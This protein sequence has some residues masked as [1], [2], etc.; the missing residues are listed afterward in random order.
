VTIR[1]SRKATS[2]LR[3]YAPAAALLS[4]LAGCSLDVRQCQLDSEC[5]AG[6]ACDHSSLG[7]SGICRSS[8]GDVACTPSQTCVNSQC[9]ARPPSI[10]AGTVTANSSANGWY[11]LDSSGATK[12]PVSVAIA[13]Y[14]SGIAS[15][16]LA[17]GSLSVPGSFDSASRSYRF[18]VPTKAQTALRE[19]A[20]P[21]VITATDG[22]GNVATGAPSNN[23]LLPI[24]NLG[25]AI[26]GISIVGYDALVGGSVPYFRQ[27]DA[28][29]GD[30]LGAI[31]VQAT[32]ADN[33]C[34]VDP[35]SL[36]L[37]LQSSPAT[38]VDIPTAVARTPGTNNWHFKVPRVGAQVA[39]G[40][41]GR[42]AFRV[43][44]TDLL[45]NPQ[46]AD[47][48]VPS[49]GGTVQ[50]AGVL[51]IDGQ[52]PSLTFDLTALGQ[53]PAP[54]S[55]CDLGGGGLTCG[56]DGNRFW[57]IGDDGSPL[58]YTAD[59]LVSSG[60]SGL[61]VAAGSA[62]CAIPGQ[63]NC[64]AAYKTQGRFE[65]TINPSRVTFASDSN[66]EGSVSVTVTAKDAVGNQA[67]ATR[68]VSITRV[69]WVRPLP[70]GFGSVKGAPV[71]APISGSRYLLVGGTGTSA[72]DTIAQI[73]DSGGLVKTA[74]NGV[75][76]P[77]LD[78]MAFSP[79]TKL[80]YIV[81]E[82]GQKMFAFAVSAA[83]LSI[84]YTC[85][86]SAGATINGA[87]ALFADGNTERA[88]VT[89]SASHSLYALTGSAGVCSLSNPRQIIGTGTVKFPS[90]DNY[91]IYV[92]YQNTG[93]ARATLSA[94]SFQ[95]A[96]LQNL[97]FMGQVGSAS[98]VQTTLYVGVNQ[99]VTYR[100]YGIDLAPFNLWTA[101]GAGAMGDMILAPP[102]VNSGLVFG[103]ADANDG[104]LRAF[105]ATDGAPAFSYNP[106]NPAK[107]ALSAVGIS[108]AVPPVYYF[109]DGSGELNAAVQ[110]GTAGA[111]A[112]NWGSSFKGK[113]A[114]GTDLS[115]ASYGTEP[116][117]GPDGTLYFAANNPANT[118]A[119]VYAIMTDTGPGVAPGPTNWPR[120][121]F[122][123]CNSNNSSL[124]NCQ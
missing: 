33:G 95:P 85:D 99:N 68:S 1:I 74:G 71:L 38:R 64:V 46:Q 8:C 83:G 86:L 3:P 90:T 84:A 25:P 18:L 88:L 48:A 112:P 97:S 110:S 96:F 23:P 61:N 103:V 50:S 53:Y 5:G 29:G 82:G 98:L 43:V 22:A 91:N 124:T 62:T 73:N 72:A 30:T 100:A 104:L 105:Q 12:I 32:I 42:I 31:D 26:S 7:G 92:S 94:G 55:K 59:D 107:S 66:G 57:R 52:P 63:P 2:T 70:S 41:Q 49:G 39:K 37:V 60:G 51:G 75:V 4:L 21:V 54:G 9:A 119:N 36:K 35:A 77:V 6:K 76:G 80:L 114:L 113:S 11:P 108:S 106:T 67:T 118:N 116:V 28:S 17:A 34:G 87:P 19:N 122:D 101:M 111:L 89:D 20:L 109:S 14:G 93:I 24:D 78:N 45:G 69:R 102:I 47:G 123:N 56:H 115:F 40:G 121:G 44:A 27:L 81:Q 120:V 65:F 16:S 58:F 117:I 15:V 79:V 10:G 13:D